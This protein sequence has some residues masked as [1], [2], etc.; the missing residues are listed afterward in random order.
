MNR[1]DIITTFRRSPNASRSRWRAGSSTARAYRVSPAVFVQC[2]EHAVATL[3]L[4]DLTHGTDYSRVAFEEWLP[5]VSE[6]F[7]N[8]M[9]GLFHVLYVWPLKVCLSPSR[10]GLTMDGYWRL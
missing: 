6:N 10:Q 8:P 2:N 7:V 9:N 1:R 3:K 5:W 4:Y